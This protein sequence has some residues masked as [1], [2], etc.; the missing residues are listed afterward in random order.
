MRLRGEKT[1]EEK[2]RKRLFYENI[3]KTI[4]YYKMKISVFYEIL[5]SINNN[6]LE[7][8]KYFM[9]KSAPISLKLE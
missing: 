7:I 5:E 8:I 2:K 4:K 3:T 9:M 1:G 6:I